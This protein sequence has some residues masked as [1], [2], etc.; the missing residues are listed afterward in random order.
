MKFRGFCD[1][2]TRIVIVGFW[3]LIKCAGVLVGNV[4]AL[5]DP[6]VPLPH[7]VETRTGEISYNGVGNTVCSVWTFCLDCQFSTRVRRICVI[8]IKAL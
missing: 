7:I 6:G 1:W 4:F 8:I 5:I 3:V 2:L